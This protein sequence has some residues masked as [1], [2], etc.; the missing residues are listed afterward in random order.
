[1]GKLSVQVLSTSEILLQNGM[2]LFVKPKGR[3]VNP[4]TPRAEGLG[5]PFDKLKAPGTAEGLSVPA[6]RQGSLLKIVSIG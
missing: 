3:D 5:L 4:S 6:G 1:M 2:T